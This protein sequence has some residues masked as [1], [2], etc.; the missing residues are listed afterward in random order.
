M[1]SN[2]SKSE[3]AVE[4][5]EGPPSKAALLVGASTPMAVVGIVGGALLSL[6]ILRRVFAGAVVTY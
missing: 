5:V 4:G 3:V 2:R 6:I 1:K